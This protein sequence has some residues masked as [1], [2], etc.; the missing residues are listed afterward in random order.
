M[1]E[2]ERKTGERVTYASIYEATRISPNTLTA[3]NRGQAKMVGIGTL[4][5]LLDF[6]GCDVS[7]LIVYE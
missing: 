3:L 6:F 1:A 5:R 2:K 7:D 4:E